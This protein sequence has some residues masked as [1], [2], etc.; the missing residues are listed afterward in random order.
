[1]NACV[2]H[3]ANAVEVE[4]PKIIELTVQRKKFI[5]QEKINRGTKPI[6]FPQAQFLDKAGDIPVVVQRQVS[7][8]QTVQKAMEVPPLQSVNRVVDIPVVAQ[9]QISTVQTVQTNTE[10]PQLQVKVVDVPVVLVEPVPEVRVV[11]KTVEDSQLQIVEKITEIPEVLTVQGV[12]VSADLRALE[13]EEFDRKRKRQQHQKHNN[14][15]QTTRQVMQ[16]Q[17][18]EREGEERDKVRKGETG[19]KEKGRAVQEGLKQKGGQVETEQGREEKEKG[20]K[21]QRGRGQESVEKDVTGWTEVTRKKKKMVQ[22]FVKVNGSKAT[23]TEVN[24]ADDKVDDVIRR[25]QKDD[26]VYVTLHGRVLKRSEKL[27]SC[28][29][30]DG[31]TMQVTSRLRGGGRHKNKRSMTETKRNEDESGKKDQQVGSMSDKCQEMT[32]DQKDALIQTIE[33]NEGYRRLITTISEAEDWECKI[34]RFGKQLQEKSEIGEE[35]AKV[36]E[37]GM[38]WAV[39]ARKRRRDDEQGKDEDKKHKQVHFSEE[40]RLEETQAESTDELKMTS[41]SEEVRTGRGSACFVQRTDEKCLTNEICRKGKGK[42]NGGKGEHGR[43]GGEGNKGAMHVE[44]LVMDEDQENMRATTSEENHEEDVR[45][46]V[47]MV[48]KE[49][50]ELEMMQKEEMEK[51]EQ[52][53]RVAPNMGASGSHPQAASDPREEEAGERRKETRRPR[54]ADCEDDEGKEEEEQETERERQQE[55]KEKKEQEKERETMPETGHKELTSEKP[56]GLEQWVKGEHE[57]EDEEQRRAQE[58]REEKR[59]A[60]EAHEEQRR[61]QKA[62]EQRKAQEEQEREAKKAQEEREKEVKAQEERERQAKEAKA[63]EE[64]EWQVR[65]TEAREEQREQERKIEAQGGHEEEGEGTTRKG[66]VEEEREET[67]SM[68]GKKQRVE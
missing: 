36:M 1:M 16:E 29:V 12:P 6:E 3:V 35:R 58:A 23:P 5:I 63:H 56:P 54:W 17:W 13:E 9:R 15:Q 7:T 50:I 61:A 32:K 27:K 39:E 25:I 10:I 49:E 67:N 60:Q 45:K 34:Q 44:N 21:G 38:R 41:R 33:R 18:G 66:S 55:T 42:G 20:R 40:E 8:A 14:E 30:T 53:G 24:L 52:R 62:L 46:F 11:K 48:Q 65:E 4:K 47:E 43:N 26:D 64:Q 59:R 28:E 2:Q 51:D 37:W 57:E 22:I 31:S 68:Q 19:K